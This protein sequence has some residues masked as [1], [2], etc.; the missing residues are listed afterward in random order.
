MFFSRCD[1]EPVIMKHNVD[2]F[3]KFCCC[4]LV[5]A[6]IGETRTGNILFTND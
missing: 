4:V 3:Y 2:S 5:I 1:I 6:K